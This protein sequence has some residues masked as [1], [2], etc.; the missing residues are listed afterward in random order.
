M[1]ACIDN[2]AMWMR[3]NIQYI[4]SQKRTPPPRTFTVF[5]LTVNMRN[6]K[7]SLLLPNTDLQLSLSS[8][9]IFSIYLNICIYY[10]T[11]TLKTLQI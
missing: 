3:S 6:L 2:M 10:I 11:F 7:L 4:A 5:S 1:S 8:Y 9:T